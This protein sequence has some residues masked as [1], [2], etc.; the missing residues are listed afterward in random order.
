[1]IAACAKYFAA[2]NIGDGGAHQNANLDELTLVEHGGSPQ[3]VKDEF[4]PPDRRIAAWEVLAYSLQEV[5][6][7]LA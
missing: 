6:D 2:H 4:V 7:A 5:S 1:M 3:F